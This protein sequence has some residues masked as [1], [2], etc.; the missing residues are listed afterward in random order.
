MPVQ[1]EV[2]YKRPKCP[3]V[4]VSGRIGK[5][6]QS[7]CRTSK[8]LWA[9]RRQDRVFAGTPKRES[10][11][12]RVHLGCFCDENLP[13]R[14]C[15]TG[16]ASLR[17]AQFQ[18]GCPLSLLGA[19]WLPTDQILMGRIWRSNVY[20]RDALVLNPPDP[21][22]SALELSISVRKHSW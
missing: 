21:R 6:K 19:T 14:D 3:Q 12:E 4:S 13:Q 7:K 16:P 5:S 11:L 20:N 9:P 8:S 17:Q 2:I 15:H 18:A 1:C 22:P 10:H